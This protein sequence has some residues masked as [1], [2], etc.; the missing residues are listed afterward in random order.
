MTR[1]LDR[2]DRRP[3]GLSRRELM[4]GSAATAGALALRGMFNGGRARARAPT[5]GR[6][7]P[8][9]ITVSPTT[10]SIGPTSPA[11]CGCNRSSVNY[12]IRNTQVDTDTGN[13]PRPGLAES[14]EATDGP[15][16]WTFKLRKDVAFHN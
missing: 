15:G 16:K 12:T 4:L 9:G 1:I 5:T 7:P 14:G 10:Y 2:S 3:G 6:T 8:A 11:C 13:R